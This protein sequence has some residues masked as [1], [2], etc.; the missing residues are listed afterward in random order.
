MFTKTGTTTVQ[1]LIV[2]YVLAEDE[3]SCHLTNVLSQPVARSLVLLEFPVVWSSRLLAS[4][5][6]FFQNLADTSLHAWSPEEIR[7]TEK[8]DDSVKSQKK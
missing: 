6:Q 7:K 2:K 1:L 4:F 5:C 3:L 8:Q